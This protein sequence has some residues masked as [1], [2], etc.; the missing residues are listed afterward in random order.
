METLRD[1]PFGQICRLL[2]HWN[3]FLYPEERDPDFVKRCVRN[4]DEARGRD[5]AAREADP[6]IGSGENYTGFTLTAQVSH[7][8]ASTHPSSNIEST[9]RTADL[10]KERT[11]AIVGWAGPDDSQNPQLWTFTKKSFVTVQICL[12]TFAIYVGSAIYSPAI[13][14]TAQHFHVSRVTATLGLSLFVAGYGLGPMVWAPL[15]EVPP[16]GRSPIYIATTLVFVCFQ[17]AVVYAKNIGM[18]L[19]FRFLTGFIGSPSLGTGGASL[20]DM[21]DAKARAYALGVWGAV[22]VCGPTLG[23]LVGGF[24]VQAKG[25]RWSIWELMW[26]SGFTLVL[27]FFCLPETS[28]ANILLRR[29]ARMRRVTRNSSLKSASEMEASK[30]SKKDLAFEAF[31]R[32]F[33]LCFSEPIVFVLNLYIALIY[34]LLYIWFEAFPIV[35]IEIHGFNLGQNGLAFLGTF[36]GSLVGSA[37]YFWWVAKVR[38]PK[39]N[40]HNELAPEEQLPPSTVGAFL[41]PISLFWFGWTSYAS[42]HWISPI[43]AG[44]FFAV[45]G[46]LVV[47]SVFNYMADAYP[48]YA[49]SALGSNDFMRSM[50]AAGFPLFATAMFHNLDVGWA[51]TLLGCLSLVFLPFPFILVRYGRRMR[52]ASRWARHDL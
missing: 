6:A 46:C 38:N 44:L 49:A 4:L 51:C 23:P 29:A 17:L 3:L 24:A 28:G 2:S 16:I 39:F 5:R 33:Q 14:S 42:I 37:V 34:G 1:A 12:L 32:L 9:N 22:A 47:N 10:E 52:M 48:P 15:S 35:F 18:F 20:C 7:V 36:V 30:T 21:W 13:P 45:G 27:L 40:E 11:I 43:M 25:W 50:F 26:A 41:L 8:K 31:V 19:A